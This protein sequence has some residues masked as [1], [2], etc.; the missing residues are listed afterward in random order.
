VL[1]V[2]RLLRHDRA[3]AAPK[4]TTRVAIEVGRTAKVF[5][6]A[7]DWPGWTRAVAKKAGAEAAL[8]A[9]DAYRERFA[10]VAAAGDV[11]FRPPRTFEV[12]ET[13]D[14][15]ASTDFGV[16]SIG[17]AAD[18]EPWTA[19]EARRQ[20]GLLRGAWRELDRVAAESSVALRKGPRGGGRDRDEVV[21]H[22]VEAERGYARKLG[23][24]HPPF[25]PFDLGPREALREEVANVLLAA[26]HMAPPVDRGWTPRYAVRRYSWHVLDHVWEIEDKQE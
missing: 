6:S 20:V 15:D 23:V 25:D 8:E 3:V 18:E 7:L 21:R 9:L 5:A 13:V 22:V 2:V 4:R 24:R 1:R 26:R 17:F 19:A 12:V 14:G 11:P 10:V 16:A